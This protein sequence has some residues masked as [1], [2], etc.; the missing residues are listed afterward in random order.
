MHLLANKEPF[1]GLG[2]NGD[3]HVLK[4]PF[5]YPE[6]C[7]GWSQQ[8]DVARTALN[9]FLV[10]THRESADQLLAKLGYRLR[11]EFTPLIHLV[12]RVFFADRNASYRDARLTA[13]CDGTN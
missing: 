8:S 11:L 1:A 10:F 7:S 4:R 2:S 5:V 12:F 6:V 13:G 9:Q 3:V